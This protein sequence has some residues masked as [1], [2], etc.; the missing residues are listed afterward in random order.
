MEQSYISRT[1]GIKARDKIGYAMGDLASCLV[2]GL[3]QSVLN[4]YYTDV[5]EISVLSVMIMTIIARIWDAINDPIWGRIIDGAKP[6][7]DGRYRRFIKF[8][9]IPVAGA[10]VLMFLDVRG[11][12]SA[13]RLVWI[14]VT[15]ILF[16][17]LYTCINIPYGSL[18][19][20]ITSDDKERSA[21]SVFRSIG[22]TFG[23]MPA[24]VL[25]SIC[26]VTLADGTKQMS[27]SK[28]FFG[29]LVIAVL[30]VIAYL[31][32]YAWSKER[33]ES[34]PA[35][36]KKG[37]TGRVIKVLLKSRPFMAVSLAS[38]LFL[39]AQ[40][41][42][43]GYNTY[44]FHY[45]FGKPGLTMLPTV[46]QYLPVAV[47]MFFATKLGNKFGRKEVC[48]YGILLAAVF[49]LALFVLALLGISS[50]WLYLAACLMSGIGTAFIFL[51]IWALA[52]DAIDYNKVTYGLNDEATSYA[53][54]SFMRKL[55]QTVATIL[56]N[57]PLLRIGYNGS[58]LK[59]EG[60]SN[61]A[62]KSMYNSSVMI[63]AVLFLLV[64]L[65][66]RFMD[67]LSKKEVAALQVKKDKVLGKA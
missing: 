41:F 14:Y 46:F 55:G 56:I 36:R 59:T 21:L 61:A 15:Y 66:L 34:K 4:K 24:M 18:A 28:V 47:V 29:A 20:V 19:Q 27:Q 17:M 62:L 48:S 42:G 7:K 65:I 10:A 23:A 38:M 54:Y 60:L 53:F 22:S 51:L 37:E 40:M 30:S 57:V 35:P 45:Y 58:Q 67:P 49:Y 6:A 13:G 39:A 5:L 1:S 8:F 31:L 2:F 12:S 52:N 63:P 44:L 16:G 32:C 33:V 11:F 3:T 9:A 26:Y 25:A 50:V 43:Q 64:F